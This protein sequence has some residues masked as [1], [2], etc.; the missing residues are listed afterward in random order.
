MDKT[1]LI[2]AAAITA[3]LG[4]TAAHATVARDVYTDGSASIE[5]RNP[6]TDGGRA[7]RFDVYA[8]GAKAGKFDSFTDGTHALM[9]DRAR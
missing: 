7:S 1:L 2:L 3:A 4:A 8:D 6:Y 9:P 5:A